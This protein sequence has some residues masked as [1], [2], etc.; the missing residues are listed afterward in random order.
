M[1][2]PDQRPRGTF[3]TPAVSNTGIPE[4]AATGTMSRPDHGR[5]TSK[6]SLPRAYIVPTLYA[7]IV[8]RHG[9]T[10]SAAHGWTK[11]HIPESS[12][13]RVKKARGQKGYAGTI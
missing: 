1:S 5:Y 2:I 8:M 6:K 12:R 10:T 3:S 13:I 4:P 7:I 9:S 11:V